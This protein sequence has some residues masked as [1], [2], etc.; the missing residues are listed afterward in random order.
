MGDTDTDPK[1]PH[2]QP[3]QQI[4]PPPPLE[5]REG[6]VAENFKAWERQM[7]IFLLASGGST[8]PAQQQTAIL[9]H[10]AGAAAM[11]VYEHF[12]FADPADKEIPT[13]V[14]EK[15]KEY[16]SPRETEV[17]HAF[18]FWHH[19]YSAPFEVFVTE[20]RTKAEACNFKSEAERMVRDKIVFS[21][22]P[23]L[24]ERLLRESS[25]TLDRTIDICR[26]YEAS[27]KQMKEIS[28]ASSVVQEQ[29]ELFVEKVQ[30]NDR[31]S[32]K[33]CGTRHVFKKH[34]CPAWGKRCDGCNGR[35]H[36]KKCCKRINLVGNGSS[37]E[38]EALPE[39][40]L[41]AFSH[42]GDRLTALMNISG[43]D[44]RFQIDTAADVNTISE[45][46]VD[47][48]VISKPKQ[49][50]VMWNKTKLVPVGEA[51]LPILNPLCNKPEWVNFT[52]VKDGLTN[53]LGLSTSLKLGF[54]SVN[55]SKFISNVFCKD[56]TELGDLGQASLVTDKT[57]KPVVL[58][59]RQVPFSLSSK[60]KEE[61][62]RL[63]QR[64]VLVSVD[65]PTRWVNQMAVVEK[66]NGK[67]RI[68]LDPQP[69]N[70]ALQREYFRLPTFE[71]VRP[72]FQN[73]KLFTKLDVK[74]AF[75]HVS[76]DDESSML[77]TMMTPWGRLRWTRLPFGLNV[78]S[79]IFQKRLIQALEGLPGVVN[80]ADD[81]V[82]LGRGQS[83]SEAEADHE[84]NLKA[85]R[86]RCQ[87]RKVILNDEKA[88][89]KQNEIVFM[90]HLISSDGIK[91]DPE[92]VQA[93]LSAPIP[94][95]VHE[96][97]RFCGMVQY[98]AKFIDGVAHTLEPL[99]GMTK[100][101]AVFHWTKECS[102]AFEEAKKKIAEA[103]MLG[104]Y[105]PNIPLELHVDS[106]QS[107]LGC[108]LLQN[109]RPLE[110]A[111]RS[112]TETE[113]RW[114]QIEKEMLAVVYG[115]ERFNQYTYGNDVL[116]VNDHKPLATIVR[117][118][119][120]QAPPRLQRL[121]MRANK[122]R[123]RFQWIQGSNLQAADYFSRVHELQICEAKTME[124]VQS[125]SWRPAGISD[126]TIERIKTATEEDRGFQD[127][128]KVI[129]IG[130][131]QNKSDLCPT[132][133][134]YFSL[135][136]SLSVCDGLVMRGEA[137]VVPPLLRKELK[138]RLHAAHLGFDSMI[139]RARSCIFWPGMTSEVKEMAITCE[140]MSS[141]ETNEL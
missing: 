36:F 90:G 51:I 7:K 80:V 106:S 67:I 74:E 61:I 134:P 69:L 121:L 24:Q 16:C 75:W 124:S 92:K 97:R 28:K 126:A 66:N 100:K 21:V 138:E 35:N 117:K 49:S 19:P 122:Y 30:A 29:Q 22:D 44:V 86:A 17:L 58:P 8:L 53:L 140:A 4:R 98:L 136:D 84:R 125:R 15:F 62:D 95:D 109:N 110:Y 40:D 83:M 123:F 112:L 72:Q 57:I 102:K 52:V 94:K 130:W 60:V 46:Y 132:V 3:L 55:D 5:L 114:A 111:S 78:S 131:P 105:D 81:I 118:P 99:H 27:K 116:V 25:L 63:L 133:I 47:P 101:N 70:R 38:K 87:E 73:A 65:Q 141:F 85:L 128:I 127:L 104:H 120:C 139:R 96:I 42:R 88:R 18:R 50:L 11:D 6:N 12:T 54:I 108:V 31:G 10:C 20:L 77:T 82:V 129:R 34:L 93:L 26:A 64:G 59:C 2:Y 23:H 39:A 91:P 119:L 33:F 14:M 43:R 48:A 89:V 71:E 135:R 32:C 76:L 113:R 103:T 56:D 45:R 9:L 115:L 1:T 68:C 79:E 41:L 107:G 13:K 37:V 137:I